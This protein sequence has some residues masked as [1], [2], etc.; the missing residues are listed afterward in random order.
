MTVMKAS[1]V[2]DST[3]REIAFPACEFN[4]DSLQAALTF[5]LKR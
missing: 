1:V 4:F 5:Q 3:V 2:L